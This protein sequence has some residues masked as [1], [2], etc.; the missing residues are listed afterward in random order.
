MWVAIPVL[1]AGMTDPNAALA[2]LSVRK[3]MAFALVAA[4]LPFLLLSAG[5]GSLALR[6][7]RWHRG[8]HPRQ[9]DQPA[10]LPPSGFSAPPVEQPGASS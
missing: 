5:M 6:A 8:K 4:L 10:A 3:R 1:R 2:G 9:P 7:W